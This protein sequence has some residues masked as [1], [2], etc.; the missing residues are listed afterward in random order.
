MIHWFAN[1]WPYL[2]VGGA[3]LAVALWIKREIFKDS[4]SEEWVASSTRV[5][6]PVMVTMNGDDWH[7]FDEAHAN[8]P[9]KWA[10][11]DSWSEEFIPR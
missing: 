2:I 7:G 11:N 3:A 4:G 6:E 1:A 5:P 9:P 10:E 8:H